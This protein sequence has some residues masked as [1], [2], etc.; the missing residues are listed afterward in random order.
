MFVQE[1]QFQ[2]LGPIIVLNIG[3][4]IKLTLTV[5]PTIYN[6]TWFESKLET[7]LHKHIAMGLDQL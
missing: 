2:Q 1:E 3:L 6:I 5:L 7:W 4:D